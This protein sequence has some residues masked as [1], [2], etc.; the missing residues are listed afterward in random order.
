M[1][2]LTFITLMLCFLLSLLSP[3]RKNDGFFFI[4]KFIEI[5]LNSERSLTYSKLDSN[6]LRSNVEGYKRDTM[7]ESTM[8]AQRHTH[9]YINSRSASSGETS[10][11]ISAWLSSISTTVMGWFK[12]FW[13][14]LK[15]AWSSISSFFTD[16]F[17]TSS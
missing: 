17:G 8:K 4:Y 9:Q 12:T 3:I 13:A 10:N 6:N 16:L 2:R 7:L 11:S 1:T 14:W 15:T 5:F